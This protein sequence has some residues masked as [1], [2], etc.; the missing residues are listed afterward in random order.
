MQIMSERSER[1]SKVAR[2]L[3]RNNTLSPPII[4]ASRNTTL[5]R[6]ILRCWIVIIIDRYPLTEN[7][8]HVFRMYI[9]RTT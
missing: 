7:L 8:R 3:G 2:F 1:I 5:S 9:Q 4:G 6:K